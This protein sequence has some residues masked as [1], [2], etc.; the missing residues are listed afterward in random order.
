MLRARDITQFLHNRYGAVLMTLTAI[1]G[2]VIAHSEGLLSPLTGD[3]GLLVQSPENWFEQGSVSI[4]V[5]IVLNVLVAFSAITLNKQYNTMR[6][7]S[8]LVAGLF[9]IM[10]LSSPSVLCYLNG[11]VVMAVGISIIT[12]LLFSIFSDYANSRRVFLI[13]FLLAAFASF[14]YS[15]LFYVPVLFLGLSQMRVFTLRTFMAAI[16]G[17]I[18]PAW[19]LAGFGLITLDSIKLPDFTPFIT[20]INTPGIWLQLSVTGFTIIL[21]LTFMAMNVM[22]MFSYNSR[23]RAANGFLTTLMLATMLFIFIDYNN[24]MVYVVLLN[25]LVSYQVG[26]YFATHIQSQNSYIGIL[27]LLFIYLSFFVLRLVL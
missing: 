23:I 27:S 21:G 18:T 1:V 25:I 3:F 7:L 8:M 5:C 16:I 13:F 26:H 15:F 22:K 19:I 2:V 9:M 14:E 12:L 11:S 6:S 10:Q 20:A 17:F 24:I 4:T